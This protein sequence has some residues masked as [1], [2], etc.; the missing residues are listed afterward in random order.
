MIALLLPNYKQKA[1][2]KIWCFCFGW[3]MDNQTAQPSLEDT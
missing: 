2:E 1:P 3:T